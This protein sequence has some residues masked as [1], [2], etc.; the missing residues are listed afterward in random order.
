MRSRF[1]RITLSDAMVRAMAMIYPN[2]LYDAHVGFAG[3]HHEKKYYFDNFNSEWR[4]TT[5]SEPFDLVSRTSHLCK[6]FK[7][8]VRNNSVTL[9][10]SEWKFADENPGRYGILLYRNIEGLT[11]EYYADIPY[12]IIKNDLSESNIEPAK[13]HDRSKFISIGRIKYLLRQHGLIS[14]EEYLGR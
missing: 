4:P 9:Q 2:K 7:F 1:E 14:H 3:D 8:S 6:D 11:F 5:G 12:E 10:G 13:G